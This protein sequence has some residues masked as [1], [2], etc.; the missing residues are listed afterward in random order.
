MH[1]PHVDPTFCTYKFQQLVA[2]LDIGL[3]IYSSILSI[4]LYWLYICLGET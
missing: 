3:M 2:I 4:C 1:N